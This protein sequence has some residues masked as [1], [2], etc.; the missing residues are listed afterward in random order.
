MPDVAHSEHRVSQESHACVGRV[1]VCN[2][3]LSLCIK[4]FGC[5]C[6][7]QFQVVRGNFSRFFLRVGYHKITEIP[8]GARNISV[9]ETV[10]SRNYL[11]IHTEQTLKQEMFLG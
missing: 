3:R 1:T 11:G 4:V 9:Q 8:S 7:Q 10:K 6:W 2:L 5:M